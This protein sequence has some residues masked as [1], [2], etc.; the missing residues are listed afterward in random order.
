MLSWPLN[1]FFTFRCLSNFGKTIDDRKY[2]KFVKLQYQILYLGHVAAL[3]VLSKDQPFYLLSTHQPKVPNAFCRLGGNVLMLLHEPPRGDDT[4]MTKVVFPISSL[5]VWAYTTSTVR[6]TLN[7]FIM[8]FSVSFCFFNMHTFAENRKKIVH[9]TFGKA[10]IR[11]FGAK[12][13][14]VA[15]ATTKDEE[16]K[17]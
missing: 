3:H 12:K 10:K 15:R 5:L 6:F 17:K 13:I 8:L 14:S 16:I 4:R 11:R 9:A 7:V 2:R 1:M